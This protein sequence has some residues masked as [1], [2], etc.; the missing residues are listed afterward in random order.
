MEKMPTKFRQQPILAI[1]I[2]AVAFLFTSCADPTHSHLP[3]DIP[4]RSKGEYV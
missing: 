1:A 4:E 2:Y 3:T